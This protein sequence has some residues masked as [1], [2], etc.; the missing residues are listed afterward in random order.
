MGENK[1][2]ELSPIQA[3]ITYV[4][5]VFFKDPSQA[6]SRIGQVIRP[7]ADYDLGG[8]ELED[9]AI[10]VRHRI[11]S[12][13]GKFLGRVHARVEPSFLVTDGTP[14]YKIELTGRGRPLEQPTVEGALGFIDLA[15][16]RLR[17]AFKNLIRAEVQARW[18]AED[19]G[20]G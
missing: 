5:H 7:W 14:V 15:H 13:D 9:V 18:M 17:I 1:L 10:R 12:D 8:A 3:E 11:L 20:D 4:N 16:Q 6:H 19:R 2:G